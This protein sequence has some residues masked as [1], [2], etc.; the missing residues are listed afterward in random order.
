VEPVTWATIQQ[1]KVVSADDYITAINIFHMAG[2]KVAHF[3]ADYDVILSPTLAQP[4]MPLGRMAMYNPNFEDWMDAIMAFS[5]YTALYN[6]TGQPAITLPLNWTGD[7]LPIG[8]MFAASFG[9]EGL[10]LRLSSQLAAAKPWH[11]RYRSVA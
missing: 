6:M 10:L 1:G 7:D 5:P 9:G 11:D 4:P 2:R 8:V 3:M